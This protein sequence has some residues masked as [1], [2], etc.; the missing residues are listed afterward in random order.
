MASKK[1]G[2]Q[3]LYKSLTLIAATLPGIQETHAAGDTKTEKAKVE[4]G[5]THW[6]EN[7]NRYDIDIYQTTVAIPLNDKMD[8]TI[9][10]ERDVMS[11]A[12]PT[13]YLPESFKYGAG[14]SPAKLVEQRSGASIA[15]IRN[16]GTAKFRYFFPD[17]N[18]GLLLG[19]SNEND[20]R[21]LFLSPSMQ[22]NL[23]KNNT[24]LNL[25]YSFSKDHILPSEKIVA[26]YLPDRPESTS[27]GQSGFGHRQT[28]S[29]DTHSFNFGIQQDFTKTSFGMLNAEYIYDSGFLSDPY[30][31]TLIW[32]NSTPV[33]PGSSYFGPGNFSFDYDRRPDSRHTGAIAGRYVQYL[34]SLESSIHLDY[35]F[36]GNSW[37][38]HSHTLQASYHQPFAETWEIVP[39]IRYYTQSAADFYAMA[40]TVAP[41]SP[42][43]STPLPS[44]VKN[45]S[46]YRLSSFGNLG[47]E[48]KINKTFWSENK[49]SFLLGYR[50]NRDAFG[51]Q[52]RGNQKNTTNDYDVFYAGLNLSI[53]DMGF[54]PNAPSSKTDAAV[55]DSSY[56]QGTFTI[57][58][59]TINISTLTHKHTKNDSRING[60]E[61]DAYATR[62]FG[63]NH[64]TR[65]GL[66]YSIEL[67]YFPLKNFEIF[68]RP[69]YTYEKGIGT[70][71]VAPAFDLTNR[72]LA[73]K[74]RSTYGGSVGG[75]KYFDIEKNGFPS[76]EQQ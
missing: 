71:W 62:G 75:R 4:A 67:G 2:L 59:L 43:P 35:R 48:I 24:A 38:V 40:F 27:P 1:S 28:S 16:Q 66:S 6:S 46:D 64:P 12:T 32:G 33:R 65:N 14:G 44:E 47:A 73:F 13:F 31:R 68:V 61:I 34:E 55:Q 50:L 9:G 57:K 17:A 26:A 49:A 51:I 60:F 10:A 21:S 58:P 70:V 53:T 37:G 22:I 54:G 39:K 5:Y 41:G 20:Y 15:D 29:K 72:S 18:V 69:S 7:K 45:S 3:D 76:L 23:N 74:S 52:R 63:L 56:K 36:A 19:G 30:K 42:F 8:M 25:A 11:G